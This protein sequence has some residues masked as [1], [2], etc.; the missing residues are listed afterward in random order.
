MNKTT[1]N[2]LMSP[3]NTFVWITYNPAETMLLSVFVFSV[4]PFFMSVG[5]PAML[6]GLISFFACISE[7]YI[8]QYEKQTKLYNILM[9][10]LLI[11]GVIAIFTVGGKEYKSTWTSIDNFL[12]TY[13]GAFFGIMITH[14]LISFIDKEKEEKQKQI[15]INRIVLERQ[16]EQRI[17][18]QK[19]KEGLVAIKKD[20]KLIGYI[21]KEKYDD[22]ISKNII[23]K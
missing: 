14:F 9:I 20:G 1:K 17:I 18:S 13:L 7:R 8:F 10:I 19:E 11:I 21:E 22:F 15:E 6:G 2:I 4:L 5:S 3:V 12:S 16:K 23:N